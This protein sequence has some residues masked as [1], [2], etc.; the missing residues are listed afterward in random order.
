LPKGTELG[1]FSALAIYF[2]LPQTQDFPNKTEYIRKWAG[3]NALPYGLLLK[4]AINSIPKWRE[5]IP[6]LNPRIPRICHPHHASIQ[7]GITP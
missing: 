5:S 1:L 4:K 7:P 6:P 3:L 2:I